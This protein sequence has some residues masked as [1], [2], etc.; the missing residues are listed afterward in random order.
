[1]NLG[2][3][4]TEALMALG[5]WVVLGVTFA[6]TVF[7]TGLVVPALPTIMTA[8]L[9]ALEGHFSLGGVA[10]ATALG[11]ALGD[12][13]GFW[14]GRKGGRRLLEGEGRFHRIARAQ[15]RRATRLAERHALAGITL[16]RCISFVRTLMPIMAGISRI[17][18]RR[19][20][21]YDLLGVA[22]WATGSI[23]VGV[24]A[25]VGWRR[26]R[27]DLG[28]AWAVAVLGLAVVVWLALKVRRMRKGVPSVVPG[29]D[30]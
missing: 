3:E 20:L 28:P 12:S 10:A 19:F 18:Y 5:P 2:P 26:V 16:A 9:L 24:S 23:L 6:E 27:D 4:L 11:G 7:I 13:T 15:E 14:L 8:C 30:G 25:S 22:V 1:M 21:A 17:P 29:M